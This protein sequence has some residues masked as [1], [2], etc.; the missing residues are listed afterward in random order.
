MGNPARSFG[1]R[2]TRP[3]FFGRSRRYE[4]LDEKPDPLVAL[5]ELIPWESFRT[6]LRSALE[7]TGQR[8]TQESRKST[9]GRKPWDEVLIVKV[10]VLNA[11]YN[12]AD[13]HIEYLTRD[14][15]SFIPF[16]GL[17]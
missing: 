1:V 7:E 17:C 6:K 15:L 14:A 4:S 5:N 2:M 11:L 13:E 8:A 10:R 12:L 9:A 3:G 16:F